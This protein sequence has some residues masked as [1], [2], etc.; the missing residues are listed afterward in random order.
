MPI[1]N[2]LPSYT[3][4]LSAALGIWLGGAW[5]FLT[6]A[7]VFL[8]I[9]LLE[10]L[11]GTDSSNHDPETEQRVKA[12]RAY[13]MLLW[14]YVPIQV[15]LTAFFLWRV[16]GALASGGGMGTGPG[17]APLEGWALFGAILSV[18]VSNG[19]T[20]ITV[21]H[22]LI[23]RPSRAEQILGRILLLTTL[24]MHFAIEH[25]YGHH[26]HVA[27][28]HD[29]AT[30]RQGESFYRFW[31][32]T[33]PAQYA[34]AW[35]I[36]R[37]RLQKKGKSLLSPDNEMAWFHLWQAALVAA[38]ALGLGWAVAAAFV[39]SAVVAFSL[40]EA[41][42]YLEHYGLERHEAEN[43]RYE[44]VDH[45]HSWNSDH[46]VSRMFL[47][48]LSRHSDHHAVASRKY[49]VLRSF[50]QSPQ[51]PTG[52][53]GMILLALVPPVWFRVMDPLVERHRRG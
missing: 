38:I 39:G 16:T 29:P 18:G 31:L 32:R 7:Y 15:A 6:P 9:P 13:S 36:E 20:G 43:G 52:Y 21:A 5:S 28:E 22:E 46:V 17:L 47:F 23:H 48:E 53:P 8:L 35:A 24:Y 14:S 1:R 30:A 42:N 34:S 41:V 37:R 44:K 27:T 10:R 12:G 50:E 26:K 45:H 19:G 51:L 3:I 49:Q 4:P 2:Y 40:L 25:V 33:V 11:A